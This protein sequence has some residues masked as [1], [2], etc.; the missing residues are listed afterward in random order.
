MARR[1]TRLRLAVP[2][3]AHAAPAALLAAVAR[4]EASPGEEMVV[5][6]V[7]WLVVSG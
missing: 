5:G 6:H 3:D 7:E 2:G 4:V 1:G